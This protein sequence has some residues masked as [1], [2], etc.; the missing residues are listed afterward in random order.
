MNY[1]AEKC[2]LIGLVMLLLPSTLASQ[3]LPKIISD[4]QT[5]QDNYLPDFSFA[6]YHNGE[7]P[8]P[9]VGGTIILATDF[10]VTANDVLDDSKALKNAMIAANNVKGSVILQL[11][12]GRI[13]LS[14]I[15]YI[16]RSHFV[17]RGTGVGEGGTELFYPRPMMYLE[18]PNG[19][20]ELREY[21]LEFDKRQ[22]ENENNIDLLF[23]QYSWSGG[24]IWTQVPGER[25]KSYLGKY[26]TPQTV[27]AKAIKGNRGA[28]TI[29]VADIQGLKVGDVVELQLFNKDGE[30]GELISDLYKNTNVKPGSHHWQ[31]P[32]LPIVK[33]QV[34]I[35][36]IAK[37]KVTIKT[38]LTMSIKPSYKAQLVTW[39]HLDEVGIEHLRITFPDTPRVAHHLEQGYNGIFLTRVFNSW[40]KDVVI[41]NAESGIL[42]EEIANVTIKDIVTKGNNIAHYTVAM[43]AVTNV[44]VS[45]LKVYNNAVHPLSFNTFSTKNVYHNCEVFVNPVLDQHSGANH[46]NLFDNITVHLNPLEDNSY[47]LFAGGG[48]SYWK[49]SHGAYSTFWNLNVQVESRLNE[50]MPLK[51]NGMNDGPFV[52]IIGV[53]GNGNYQVDYKPNAYIEFENKSI[54]TMPSLYDYQLKKRLN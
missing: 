10:G 7:K 27:L 12:A 6:G 20:A 43:A 14:D 5:I 38:P 19:L 21:L 16:E 31:F 48:A 8:L 47:P 54:E 25:V 44:L 30:K 52:R 51:L 37:N 26:D 15:L 53:Y 50:A 18:N 46:Q 34:E 39:K 36:E 3:S 40:V 1:F 9:K 13:I 24:Y 22:I 28:H 29:E 35:L 33:Q 4:K 23:S 11:P 17:L 49:P 32:N 45:N 41:H 42:T 2:A